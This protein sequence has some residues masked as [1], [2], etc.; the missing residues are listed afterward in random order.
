MSLVASSSTRHSLATSKQAHALEV[1]LLPP[2][3]HAVDDAVDEAHD[4]AAPVG[5]DDEAAERCRRREQGHHAV[6]I[7]VL[8]VP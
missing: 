6:A 1:L 5:A 2:I 4:V 8:P 7:V 3:W